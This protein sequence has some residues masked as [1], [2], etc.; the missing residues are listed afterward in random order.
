MSAESNHKVRTLCLAAALHAF[1]HIY[2][3]ALMPLYLLI[4]RDFQLASV[5]KA[6]LLVTVMMISYF[7]PSYPM[8]ML[9][10]RVSRKKLLGIGLAINGL[11]FI[12]LS[13]APNYTTAL[14]CV[15]VA[16]FGGSFFHP[17]ATAMIARLFPVGTG[18]ALGFLGIGAS[19]GFFIGPIYTGWRAETAGWR[20]PVLEG[21]RGR[22]AQALSNLHLAFIRACLPVHYEFARRVTGISLIAAGLLRRVRAAI[23]RP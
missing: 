2:H 18:R 4:Q 21:I 9:A 15:V 3:V 1:T 20:A 5:G 19:I 17:A 10:D 23:A 16:G 12:G 8:G 13:Q 6:T 7:V 11:G 22:A 14:A